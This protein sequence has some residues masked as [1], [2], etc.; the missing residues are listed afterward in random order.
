[1]SSKFVQIKALLFKL[2]RPWGPMFRWATPGPSWPSCLL[3]CKCSQ[4]L[5][6]FPRSIFLSKIRL[7]WIIPW[8]FEENLSDI[9]VF[10]VFSLLSSFVHHFK[11]IHLNDTS[12]WLFC[13]H[14][15]QL[16]DDNNGQSSGLKCH[17]LSDAGVENI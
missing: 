9:S 12:I 4:L 17:L 16:L 8:Y 10:I 1:V 3:W 13:F 6:S 2:A 11:L 7:N 15:K 5:R 14:L